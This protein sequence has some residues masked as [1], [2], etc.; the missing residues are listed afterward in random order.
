LQQVFE[1]KLNKKT[2]RDHLRHHS[3]PK[4]KE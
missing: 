2:Q 4:L 1:N 3:N